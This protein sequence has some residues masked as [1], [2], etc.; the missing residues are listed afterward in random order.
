MM[1]PG[2]HSAFIHCTLLSHKLFP[3]CTA[4]KSKNTGGAMTGIK[5][6]SARA[7]GRKRDV[8]MLSSQTRLERML[9]GESRIRSCR[10]HVALSNTAFSSLHNSTWRERVTQWCYDVADHLNE[11][12]EVV[13]VAMNMLDRYIAVTSAGACSD[14]VA[15]ELAAITALFLAIRVSGSNALEVSDLLQMSRAGVQVK[16]IVSEGNAMLEAL[17]WEHKLVT[18]I[19]FIKAMLSTNVSM[20]HS[21]AVS[22]LELSSYMVE[23]SVCD[24]YFIGVQ[25]SKVAFASMVNVLNRNEL[26]GVTS[27]QVFQCI[28]EATGM[29][30]DSPEIKEIAARMK[31][32]YCQSEESSNTNDNGPH[33]ISD[34]DDESSEVAPSSS[35]SFQLH[36][37]FQII[38]CE[39]HYVSDSQSSCLVR[40]MTPCPEEASKRAR[41]N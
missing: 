40:P 39:T 11:S 23:I 21:K 12:R 37:D 27:S 30:P 41:L 29:S 7:M 5:L 13:Y 25:S 33:L 31:A 22:I 6:A 32:V 35:S 9:E 20:E 17:S 24:Q 15:Y 34:F 19:D 2:K 16:D 38:T 3:H 1:I 28:H 36:P 14:K 10:D 8:N 26:D 18:P 4:P